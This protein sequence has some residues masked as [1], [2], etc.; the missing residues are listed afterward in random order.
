MNESHDPFFAQLSRATPPL[1]AALRNRT[2]VIARTSLPPRG[3][4][5]R[6][7]LFADYMPPL[8][9]VPSLLISAAAALIVDVFLKAAR[10]FWMS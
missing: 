3:T 9:L 10:L 2:L 8:E 1:S 7:L 5:P 4:R 6:S